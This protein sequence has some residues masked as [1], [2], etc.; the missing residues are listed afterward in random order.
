MLRTAM[1]DPFTPGSD[2]VPQVWAGRRQQL[3]EFAAE[4]RPRRLAGLYERGRLFLGEPGVGK[5]VLARRI[6][7]MAEED[8]DWVTEQIRLPRGVDPF[9]LLAEGLLDVAQT[10]APHLSRDRKFDDL[11]A[12]VELLSV[13]GIQIGLRAPSGRPAHREL[14]DLIVALAGQASRAGQMLLIHLDEVQNLDV[15]EHA[16]AVLTCLGDALNH[17]TTRALPGG[18]EQD[19]HLPLAVY[20][21]GLPEFG[22]AATARQGATFTRRFATTLLRPMAEEDLHEAL[23]P[24]V[25]GHTVP[26]E[27]GNIATVTLARDA[28]AAIVAA[29]YQDPFLFQLVGYRAW[30]ATPTAS[31]ITRADVADALERVD[32]EVVLHVDRLL[33]RLAGLQLGFVTAMVS[34]PAGERSLTAIA[35]T[36]GRDAAGLG[37]TTQALEAKGVIE[38]GRPYRLLTP[39]IEARLVG[40]LARE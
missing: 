33:A 11:I 31:M 16:S 28:A 39:A 13:S 6:A 19:D 29:S 34:L 14:Y 12:R 7:Q 24:L 5:S 38:R 30:L 23:A 25:A 18:G 27:H 10:H 35:G 4:V 3:A 1:N 37:S 15:A 2:H 26:D 40:D 36:L 21:T 20:L 32:E 22:D 8:G 17:V 9:Q